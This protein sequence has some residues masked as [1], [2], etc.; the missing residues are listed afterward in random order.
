MKVII[1][2]LKPLEL[3]NKK[4]KKMYGNF[5]LSK[6]WHTQFKYILLFYCESFSFFPAKLIT[7]L[8]KTYLTLIGK[9]NGFSLTLSS[10]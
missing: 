2:G 6:K 9:F 5:S 4:N 10:K 7:N 8:N 1:V 3:D